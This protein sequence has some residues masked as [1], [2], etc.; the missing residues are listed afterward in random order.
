MLSASMGSRSALSTQGDDVPFIRGL[1]HQSGTRYTAQ[2]CSFQASDSIILTGPTCSGCRLYLPCEGD[3]PSRPPVLPAHEFMQVKMIA[4]QLAA[5]IPPRCARPGRHAAWTPTR[6][7]SPTAFSSRPSMTISS[8]QLTLQAV[9]KHL[10]PDGGTI[11]RVGGRE[12][13][14]VL[15]PTLLPL[16]TI[17]PGKGMMSPARRAFARQR[18]RPRTAPPVRFRPE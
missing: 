5:V 18:P 13:S 3:G 7:A 16:R 17:P 15:D 14:F 8:T 6:M 10:A 9:L 1:R 2:G 12:L 4:A 11:R